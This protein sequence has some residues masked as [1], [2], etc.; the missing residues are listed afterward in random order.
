MAI[1]RAL[2]CGPRILLMDEPLANLDHAA[3][4][5]D[6]S[7]FHRRFNAFARKRAGQIEASLVLWQH[8][9]DTASNPKMKQV[10][11]EHIADCE[12][13]IA[14]RHNGTTKAGS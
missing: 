4:R 8:L 7:D 6:A 12:R 11:A 14:E 2:L 13:L 3:R 10:A 1:G 5:P 9:Y